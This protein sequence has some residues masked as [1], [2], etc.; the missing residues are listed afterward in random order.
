CTAKVTAPGVNSTVTPTYVNNTNP[1]TA[2]ASYSYAG[3]TNVNA[4]SASATFTIVAITP[5]IVYTGTQIANS[6][7]TSTLTL[8][9]TTS[10]T[11]CT[12]ALSYALDRNPT[13]GAAGSY[14]LSASPVSTLGWVD[15]V[16]VI[17]SARAASAGCLAVSDNQSV[18]TIANTTSRAYGG[19]KYTVTGQPAVSVGWFITAGT[20]T[21]A[22]GQFQFIQNN[23][24]KYVGNLTTYTKT[25]TT[26]VSTGTGTLSY[27]NS[28]TKAWVS[29]GSAI[30]VSITYTNGANGTL[31][32]TFTYTPKTGE[33]ALPTTAAQK[34]G[35]TI[36]VG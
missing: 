20:T 36:K 3:T 11:L 17:T 29:V 2:T 13:T 15:G 8:S 19:G 30:P 5:T 4:S 24:W 7:T 21:A 18:V 33:P 14:A 35:T 31:A 34:I 23:T 28:T 22:T 1:G 26:G 9:S 12:G 10:S 27:W 16:Y 25:G 6:A 32:T